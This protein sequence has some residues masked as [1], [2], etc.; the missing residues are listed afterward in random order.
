MA[1]RIRSIALP[2]DVRVVIMME[3]L[4]S[5]PSTVGWA[6]SEELPWREH[7]P[8]AGDARGD[9][10]PSTDRLHHHSNTSTGIVDLH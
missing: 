9:D 7:L 3:T 4:Y 10:A 6:S 2:M 8:L 5:T 1:S